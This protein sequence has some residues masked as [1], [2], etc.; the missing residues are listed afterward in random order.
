M[1]ALG[2]QIRPDHSRCGRRRHGVST[3][4]GISGELA[5]GNHGR[6]RVD[7]FPGDAGPCQF[8][9]RG[10]RPSGN[11]SLRRS[12]AYAGKR[13]QVSG[14]RRIQIEGRPAGPIGRL[15]CGCTRY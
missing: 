5:R 11:N 13:L 3:T 9:H 6:N 14:T 12:C 2:L 7:S 4:A 1:V 10:V 8:P 15:L